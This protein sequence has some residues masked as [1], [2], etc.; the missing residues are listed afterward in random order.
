MPLTV[1][2]QHRPTPSLNLFN[3]VQATKS[4]VH[5]LQNNNLQ[6]HECRIAQ[7]VNCIATLVLF[8][9]A[10]GW[11]VAWMMGVPAPIP[12]PTLQRTAVVFAV[13]YFLRNVI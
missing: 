6:T 2:L 1:T 13:S 8:A 4:K 10:V 3:S 11:V 5:L 9:G 7:L 12:N